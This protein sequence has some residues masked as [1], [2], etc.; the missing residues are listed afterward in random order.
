MENFNIQSEANWKKGQRNLITV[1]KMIELDLSFAEY[2]NEV[3][4][5]FI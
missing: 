2:Q 5:L 3:F 4:S 1:Y